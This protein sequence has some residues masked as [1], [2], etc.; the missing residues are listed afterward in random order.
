MNLLVVENQNLV[1]EWLQG[2]QQLVDVFVF[3]LSITETTKEWKSKSKLV[4][5]MPRVM[6]IP[7]LNSAFTHKSRKKSNTVSPVTGSIL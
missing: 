1:G 7:N 3:P 2:R 4:R 6:L 5:S